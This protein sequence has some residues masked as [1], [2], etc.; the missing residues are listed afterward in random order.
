MKMSDLLNEDAG[1][2]SS[3]GGIGQ[4]NTGSSIAS[5]KGKI[6]PNHSA[7]IKNLAHFPALSGH[8]YD[9][10]RFGVH[11]AGAHND[12]A[13]AGPAANDLMTAAYTEADAQIINNSRKAMGL[14]I[15]M[16]SSSESKEPEETNTTSPTANKKRNRY[17][18]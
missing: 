18:V 6:H 5:K 14:K 12:P 9:M 16:L 7:A 17:G 1:G 11:M 8:Y 10:Y 15:D 2:D 3:D 4:G 13:P